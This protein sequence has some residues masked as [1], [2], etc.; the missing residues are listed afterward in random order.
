MYNGPITFDEY[1]NAIIMIPAVIPKGHL[2]Q[3][4]KWLDK[5]QSNSSESKKI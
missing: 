1:G 3:Y 4:L 2:E 5:C